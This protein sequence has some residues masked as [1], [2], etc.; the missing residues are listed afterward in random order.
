[1]DISNLIYN[2][3]NNININNLYRIGDNFLIH[4]FGCKNIYQEH[5]DK[6]PNTFLWEYS[7]LTQ[8][9]E[10]PCRHTNIA[11]KIVWEMKMKDII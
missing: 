5:K 9:Y 4:K 10:N 3:K 1:M 8:T 11:A 6:F 2:Q 7:R